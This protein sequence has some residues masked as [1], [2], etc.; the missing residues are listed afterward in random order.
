MAI[1]EL[2][3]ARWWVFAAVAVVA[4]VGAVTA[5]STPRGRRAI[6]AMV[7]RLPSLGPIT[8]SLLTAR[9]ARVLGVL[10]DSQVPLL[11]AL[12]L[13]RESTGNSLYA[14]LIADSE[15]AVARGETFSGVLGNSSLINPYVAEALRHG[16]RS[17][18]ISPV[19]LDMADF[20]DEENEALVQTL[21]RLLEPIMLIVLGVVVGIIALSLF[22]PL[23][24]L[25]SLTQGG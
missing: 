6:D 1:S 20:M 7:V 9:F 5:L 21:A 17:G 22:M 4:G 19:L 14:A 11:A 16:E 18:Q 12:Q 3:R 25:T 2:L 13:T 10:L 8:R 23:F 24:D 15:N